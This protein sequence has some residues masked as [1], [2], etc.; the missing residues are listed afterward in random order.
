MPTTNKHTSI[1]PIQIG[2]TDEK[3]WSK[4]KIATVKVFIKQKAG[5]RSAEQKLHTRLLSLRLQMEAYLEQESIDAKQLQTIETFLQLYLKTLM[6][7][8]KKF[9]EAIETTDGNLKK[10]LSGD[11]KFNTDLAMK[12]GYFF[13]TAPELWLRIQLK[14]DFITLNREKKQITKYKKY[15]YK[16]VVELA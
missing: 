11:R 6:I 1:H 4:E 2:R 12:F 13:H 16:K 14:N 8:F 7:T 5:Q 15:D 9:A 3:D 10:Y